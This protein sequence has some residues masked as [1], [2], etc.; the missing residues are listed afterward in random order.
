M[1]G[2]QINTMQRLNTQFSN[3]FLKF[4]SRLSFDKE[5]Q[6]QKAISFIKLYEQ[7]GISKDRILIKLSSTWE[8]IQAAK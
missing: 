2:D 1:Q 3:H 4:Y 7:E 8:G 6:I 5:G